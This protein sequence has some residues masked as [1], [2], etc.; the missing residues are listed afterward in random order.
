MRWLV[1]RENMRRFALG[2]SMYSVV[3]PKRG[4]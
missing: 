2:D 3:N 1:I 4:Y